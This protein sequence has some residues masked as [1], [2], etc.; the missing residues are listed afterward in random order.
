[1]NW[2]GRALVTKDL[3]KVLWE[4]HSIHK[5]INFMYYDRNT[6][7]LKKGIFDTINSRDG[8][9]WYVEDNIDSV[10]G[11]GEEFEIDKIGP[12]EIVVDLGACIG[13][14]TLRAAR[15]AKKV[16]AVEPL[17]VE[18]LTNNI[19]LNGLSNVEVIGV[20]IGDGSSRMIGFAQCSSEVLTVPFEKIRK[21]IGHID[22]IKI[23]IEGW[24]WTI[25]P[26]S[27]NGIN[28]IAFEPH[29]RIKHRKKDW[30]A[31]RNW[32]RWLDSNGYK[33]TYTL[34]CGNGYPTGPYSALGS[35]HAR[36]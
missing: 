3:L 22:Y 7:I 23:D 10:L 29:I 32:I 33:Y 2:K 27:L 9:S 15:R 35:L 31:F 24:E 5:V 17:F 11:I 28:R 14:F 8:L 12:E 16:Y 21:E 30:E 36:K 25:N 13:A 6:I 34:K 18:E 19:R 1:M 4:T 20:G 26:N